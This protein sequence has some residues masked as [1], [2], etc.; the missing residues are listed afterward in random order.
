[1]EVDRRAVE[2][3]GPDVEISVFVQ[4]LGDFQ[5]DD[6]AHAVAGDDNLADTDPTGVLSDEPADDGRVQTGVVVLYRPH[7]AEARECGEGP[8][9]ITG[10]HI[11]QSDQVDHCCTAV[12]PIAGILDVMETRMG[13]RQPLALGLH[14]ER[15]VVGT[16]NRQRDE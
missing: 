11:S 16:K 10:V 12:D 15:V 13:Q 2:Y 7:L 14:I 1:V 3:H 5:S 8:R 4:V 9:R 6:A